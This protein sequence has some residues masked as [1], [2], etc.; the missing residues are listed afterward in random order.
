MVTNTFGAA[1]AAPSIADADA[2]FFLGRTAF[3]SGSMLALANNTLGSTSNIGQV[4]Q[5]ASTT[6]S[7]WVAMT[8]AGTP[9]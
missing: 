7:L 3:A 9:T 6:R 1:D 2:E 8:S 4:L 5:P